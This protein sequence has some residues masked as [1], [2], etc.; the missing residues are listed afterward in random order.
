MSSGWID[1]WELYL[2]YFQLTTEN[3]SS[4]GTSR[5]WIQMNV[6][7]I[8]IKNTFQHSQCD[9]LLLEDEPK[10]HSCGT[11][12]TYQLHFVLHQFFCLLHVSPVSAAAP[13]LTASP[14]L[15]AGTD[16]RPAVSSMSVCLLAS[17]QLPVWACYILLGRSE[18]NTSYC[19]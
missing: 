13:N 14:T 5:K 18:L 1:T 4:A 7:S 11:P 9:W 2:W 3:R 12:V 19:F 15:T 6:L 10:R 8:W 16:S 17:E